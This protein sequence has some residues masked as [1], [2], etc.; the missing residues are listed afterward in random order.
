VALR[1]RNK[2]RRWRGYL[3]VILAV[4][5]FFMMETFYVVEHNL[6]PAFMVIAKGVARRIAT[7]AI[8]DSIT[9]KLSQEAGY[10]QL[11]D[12]RTNKEGQVI[13]A[14]LNVPQVLRIQAEMTDQ[15]QNVLNSLKARII[16]VPVGQA[17]HSSILATFG[18][19]VPVRVLPFGTANSSITSEVRQAGINQTVHIL[20]LDVDVEMY[21]VVPF[22]TEPADIHSRVPLAY[23]VFNG[24]VPQFFYDARGNPY[25][26][27]GINAL[28]GLPPYAGLGTGY[29]PVTSS[30][31]AFAHA[32]AWKW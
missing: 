12:V 1:L 7:E 16:W 14:S 4:F 30:K 29:N 13:S 17:F 25:Y 3:L 21:V 23:V 10:S 11:L 27:K 28:P 22:I 19:S 18:P 32:G 26:P 24:D 15:V 31:V 8:N 9:R 20:Y 6:R 2:K 5:F